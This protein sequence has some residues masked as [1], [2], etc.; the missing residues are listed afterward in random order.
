MNTRIGIR[1]EDKNKWEKRVPLT[2][3]DVQLLIAD[4]DLKIVVQP[5]Q[6]HRIF[7]DSEYAKAGAIIDED[8]SSCSTIIGVKEI[9]DQLFQPDT[10][11]IFFSH[12]IKGQPYN[13]P[14]LQTLMEKNCTL[15]DY[16]KFEDNQNRRLIFFG[17]HAGLAGMVETLWAVFCQPLLP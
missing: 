9:P 12:V 16:E 13:M 5:S 15:L 3:E 1:R 10:T 14:M 11:Y 4:H 7:P 6:D 2:P 8:L 17:R